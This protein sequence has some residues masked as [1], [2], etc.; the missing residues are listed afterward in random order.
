MCLDVESGKKVWEHTFPVF[1]TDI[2][3]SRLGWTNIAADPPTGNIYAHGTQGLFMCL[4]GKTGKVIWQHS[5]GEEYGRVS[6]YGGHITSPIVDQNTGDSRH[7]Q[8]ELG[9]AGQRSEPLRRVQQADRGSRLVVRAKPGRAAPIIPPRPSPRSTVAPLLICGLRMEAS[10]P[11]RCTPAKSSGAIPIS[12]SARSTARP[13]SKAISSTSATARKAE[14][15]S[16]Q[17]RVICLDASKVE[18][19]VCYEA[20]LAAGRNPCPLR[21]PDPLR[22]PIVYAR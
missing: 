16:T 21:L 12:A 11:S 15:T 10:S 6:G 14:G 2:V 1:H 8:F 17:G 7:G 9:R 22:R 4:D 13:S 20:G 18:K 19:G 5:M 3:T